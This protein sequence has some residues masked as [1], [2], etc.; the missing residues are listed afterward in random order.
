MHHAVPHQQTA[1]HGTCC[2]QKQIHQQGLAFPLIS[3]YKDKLAASH[4]LRQDVC[5]SRA[6]CT[7]AA[8]QARHG[9]AGT[10]TEQQRRSPILEIA[11]LLA[12]C[13]QHG[14]RTIAFC[15]TRKVCELVTSYTREVLK[16]TAPALT[17][18]LA[19]YRCATCHAR[20][21]LAC[22]YN[23][24]TRACARTYLPAHAARRLRTPSVTRRSCCKHARPECTVAAATGCA[25]KANSASMLQFGQLCSI[26]TRT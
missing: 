4:G 13:I 11:M 22:D 7:K 23:R 15:K 18:R 14:L 24:V 12:E 9:A 5:I 17:G 19:V 8:V 16:E 3:A 6:F 2:G 1:Y 10:A 25:A 20:W 26:S 21:C